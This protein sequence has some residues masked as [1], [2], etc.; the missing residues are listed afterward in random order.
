MGPDL[1]NVVEGAPSV[2]FGAEEYTAK[3]A[4]CAAAA[5]P[6]ALVAVPDATDMPSEPLPDMLDILML[7]VVLPVPDTVIVPFAVPVLTRP[8]LAFVSVT[9]VAS[10]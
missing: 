5:E 9:A 7:R 1:V 6:E 4:L 2:A 10:V 3:V 8:I